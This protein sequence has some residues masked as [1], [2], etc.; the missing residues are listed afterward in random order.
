MAV[1]SF[2]NFSFR[3]AGAAEPALQSVSLTIREGEFV[4]LCGRSGS[5]KTTLLRWM[6]PELAPAGTC[7]GFCGRGQRMFTRRPLAPFGRGADMEG[8][9]ATPRP[10]ASFGRGADMEGVAATPRPLAS[11]GRGADMEGIAATR[12]PL[13]SSGDGADMEGIAATRRPLPNRAG[14][15]FPGAMRFLKG[16]SSCGAGFVMQDPDNQIVTN[17]VGHELAF[18]LENLCM[19]PEVIRR[20]VAETAHFFGIGGD[21]ARRTDTLSGGQKQLLNLAAVTAMRPRLLLLDEPTAQ[22]DPAAAESFLASLQRLNRETGTTVVLSVHDLEDV[23][24]LADRVLF[25][26]NGALRADLPPRAFA[27]SLRGEAFSAALPA[28]ARLPLLPGETVPVTVREGRAYVAKARGQLAR[29]EAA[30][31]GKSAPSPKETSGRR[32]AAMPSMYAP[33]PKGASGRRGHSVSSIAPGGPEGSAAFVG[34]GGSAVRSAA[35][36][37]EEKPADAA[38]RQCLPCTRR[39]RREPAD[40]VRVRDVWY[41]YA[42]EAD[43]AL[44]GAEL[45]VRRGEIHALVGG[46][47]SGKSTLLKLLSGVRRPARGKIRLQGGLRAAL[48]P[49]DPKTLFLKETLLQDLMECAGAFS[50]SETQARELAASLGISH[51]LSRHPYDLSGGELQKAALAKLLLTKPEILLLDEPSKGIDACAKETLLT[52]LRAQRDEGRTIVLVTHDLPFAAALADRCTMLFAGAAVCTADG[53]DFFC[54][55]AVYTTGTNRVTRGLLP[56]CVLPEDV[57]RV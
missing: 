24:P 46:N 7:T 4:L 50:Y 26:E 53:R 13:V 2:V 22:L 32:A 23:L 41:R 21:L 48:L 6:K 33:R 35:A 38:Q 37:N 18:G 28:A 1:F 49:Q 30:N 45:T 36:Q 31:A 56:G 15:R 11:F 8:V 19:P 51:L 47:G 17:T 3:Y 34:A 44:R 42:P 5:G 54:G 52:L 9:A 55:N 39:D 25:L 16:A 27:A 29:R 40:A 43:F 14:R 20:R 12:R 10:L 57:V